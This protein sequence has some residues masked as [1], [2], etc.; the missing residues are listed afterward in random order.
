MKLE[1]KG[2]D[3]NISSIIRVEIILAFA[4][5]VLPTKRTI[6]NYLCRLFDKFNVCS[7][8]TPVTSETKLC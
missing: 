7:L 1:V 8:A 3:Q 4:Y 6:T 5:F 2:V